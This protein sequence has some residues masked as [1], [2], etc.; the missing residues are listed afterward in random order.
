MGVPFAPLVR[1][2]V[3]STREWHQEPVA[4]GTMLVRS[5]ARITA[6]KTRAPSGAM[7]SGAT[8]AQSGAT[9]AQSGATRARS[10]ATA[11][12]HLESKV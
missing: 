9:H 11:R 7:P 2:P 10:G 4:I 3:G 6:E 5:R 12:S 1:I 8:H